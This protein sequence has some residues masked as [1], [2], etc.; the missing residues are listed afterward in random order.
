MQCWQTKHLMLVAQVAA[1]TLLLPLLLLLLSMQAKLTG[2]DCLA[3]QP[4]CSWTLHHRQA[5]VVHTTHRHI[6][7]EERQWLGPDAAAASVAAA[8][9]R[10]PRT[11]SFAPLLMWPAACAGY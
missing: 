7:T 6:L 10:S 3:V 9:K 8:S 4:S 5:G 1:V 2:T 11:C